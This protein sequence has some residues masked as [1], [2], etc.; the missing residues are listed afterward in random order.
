[1]KRAHL[2]ILALGV[3]ALSQGQMNHSGSQSGSAGD[4]KQAP[5]LQGLGSH[6]FPVSTKNAT[7]QKLIDQGLV[8]NYAFNH[9]EAHR[10]FV[11]AA[12]WD[13]TLAMAYWGQALSLGP[14][15]N[16]AMDDANVPRAWESL[17]KAIKLVGNQI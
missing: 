14:H 11:Y 17:Q 10:S 13:S 12:E 8:L 3:V 15:I 1:M 6:T 9:A 5:I 7:A 16:A 2:L 4:G